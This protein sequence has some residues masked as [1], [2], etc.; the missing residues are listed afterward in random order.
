M[1]GYT[2]PTHQ[3][4]VM[5]GTDSSRAR[6]AAPLVLLCL[7]LTALS[8]P[9]EARARGSSPTAMKKRAARLALMKA[10]R[11]DPK[12]VLRPHFIR[13]ATFAGFDLPVTLRLNPALSQT[14]TTAPTN[15]A[16]QIDLGNVASSPPLPA[17]VTPGTVSS[18]LSGRI[19]GRLRFSQDTAGYGRV[20]LVEFGFD[21]VLLS[22][23]GFPLV[24]DPNAVS[25]G[26]TDGALLRTENPVSVG[27][28]PGS[29]GY[30]DLLGNTFSFDLHAAFQFHSQV[31]ASCT[32]AFTFTNL[33]TGATQPPLP[34]RLDGK[35]R[36]SPALTADGRV[37]LGRLALSGPQHDSFVSVHSCTAAPPP[38]ICDGTT[39]EGAVAGRLTA[40]AFT[41][42]LL[43]G[44]VT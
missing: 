20:G 11:K 39:S 38:A 13:K 27:G 4:P 36:M 35:F 41:A 42:E 28:A 40:T 18:S 1:R 22:G 44:N 33:M 19:V 34:V 10:V 30:L 43:V 3:R 6:A 23:S 12:V 15:D 9:P 24:T 14:G 2:A 7:A 37:R 26:C 21:Q 5:P 29:S 31:R 25:L 16:A 17:G 8:A 32:D